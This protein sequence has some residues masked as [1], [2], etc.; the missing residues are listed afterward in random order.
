LRAGFDPAGSACQ[1]SPKKSDT[2]REG[3]KEEAERGMNVSG[4]PGQQEQRGANA[5]RSKESIREIMVEPTEAAQYLAGVSPAM[6][7]RCQSRQN[8]AAWNTVRLPPRPGFKNGKKKLNHFRF[9]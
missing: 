4:Q 7:S 2:N 3:R 5:T 8:Q 9:Y 1:A 6:H